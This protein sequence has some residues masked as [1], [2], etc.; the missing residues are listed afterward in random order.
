MTGLVTGQLHQEAATSPSPESHQPVPC[1]SPGQGVQQRGGGCL[2][3]EVGV[4]RE[5]A[6]QSNLEQ[7]SL[8][9]GDKALQALKICGYIS[10]NQRSV[11]S[12]LWFLWLCP[13]HVP[14]IAVWPYTHWAGG[15]QQERKPSQPVPA[16][17]CPD[18]E[19][20]LRAGL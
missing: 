10:P 5:D 17:H 2:R 9:R 15:L 18:L 14:S 12:W 8:T 1:K 20:R 3:R 7:R 16:G 19:R 11:P 6:C 13:C 4:I